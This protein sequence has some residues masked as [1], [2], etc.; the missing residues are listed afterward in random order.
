MTRKDIK[1]SRAF[2]AQATNAIFALCFFMFTYSIILLLGVA[3]TILCIYGGLTIISVKPSFI[4]LA[5]GIGLSSMGILVLIFLVKFMFNSSKS[6]DANLVEI[7]ESQEPKLF[8][9]IRELVQEVG[10]NFPKKVYLSSEV[11]A[12]VFYDSSFWSMFLP[13]KKNLRIGLGLIN[14]VTEEELK[15]I[16]AHEFGHFSQRT[17]K[18]GSYVY[19]V[20]QVIFNM[21]YDNESYS[22][23]VQRWSNISMFFSLFVIIAVKINEGIQFILRKLYELVNKSYMGL[24]REMEFHADEIAASVTGYEPFKK[25]LLRI[26]LADASLNAVLNYYGN[27]IDDNIKSENIYLEQFH[28]MQVLGE[29]NNYTITN[30]LPNIS[31]EEQ[32]K[33]NKSKLVIKDQWASHPTIADRIARLEQTG[34]LSDAK[35]DTLA[36]TLFT[37]PIAVQKQI[38]NHVFQVVHYPGEVKTNA[39][40]AFVEE[41]KQEIRSNSFGKIYNGYYDLKN[42]VEFDTQ[43]VEITSLDTDF[44]ALFSDEKVELV[45]IAV[46]LQ[47]DIETLKNIAERKLQLKTFDYDGRRFTTKEA[48]ALIENLKSELETINEQIKHNDIR[49]YTY[50]L[51]LEHSQNRPKELESIYHAFFTFDHVYESKFD[52]YAQLLNGLQFVSETTTYEEIIRNFEEVKPMEEKLK[53]E[54]NALLSDAALSTEIKQELRT[55]LEKYTRETWQY[56]DGTLYLDEGLNLLFLAVNNYSFLLARKYFLMKKALLAYQ[57]ELQK[58]GSSAIA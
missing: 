39:A 5:L 49:V 41:Y 30:D 1:L 38:T 53:Q 52:L 12:S 17:M 33:F 22:A 58:T 45:Y 4:T 18:V 28:V 50:F 2:K 20:N 51:Q 40:L 9:L 42:P 37:D 56:F 6:D 34:F 43:T 8:N 55:E 44:S 11:N 26:A 23:L 54:I 21:L 46:A 27:K 29:V 31:L 25:A 14:T 15:A 48:L 57:E 7:N 36:N 19:N 3:L 47:N 13:V 24:S 16:L 32:N 35:T 10:T